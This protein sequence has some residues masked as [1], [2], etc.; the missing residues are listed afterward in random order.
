MATSSREGESRPRQTEE[1][2]V[3]AERTIKDKAV[4]KSD[5]GREAEDATARFLVTARRL[6]LIFIE[7]I[8]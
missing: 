7:C 6:L 2:L 5:L 8:T 3:E 1:G 4:E